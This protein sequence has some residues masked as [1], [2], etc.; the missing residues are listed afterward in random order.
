MEIEKNF[1]EE[2]EAGK[3]A[4][5]NRQDQRISITPLAAMTG[6]RQIIRGY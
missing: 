6:M 5:S 3:S 2:N 1:S 4:G